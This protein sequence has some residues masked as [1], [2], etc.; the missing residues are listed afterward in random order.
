MSLQKFRMTSLFHK[1]PSLRLGDTPLFTSCEN[2]HRNS[3]FALTNGLL[4]FLDTKDFWQKD[5]N[6]ADMWSCIVLYGQVLSGMVLFHFVQSYMALYGFL[7]LG[8]LLGI[9]VSAGILY[10]VLLKYL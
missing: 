6:G 5:C 10:L 3:K 9:R 2:F 7:G 8:Q 4:A 1:D